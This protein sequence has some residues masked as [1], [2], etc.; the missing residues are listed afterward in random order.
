MS[1]GWALVG[2]YDERISGITNTEAP[3]T[4]VYDAG[5]FM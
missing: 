4:V 5:G 1:S 2:S 3:K